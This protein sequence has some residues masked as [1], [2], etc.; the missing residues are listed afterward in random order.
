MADRPPPEVNST[1][2]KLKLVYARQ[3]NATPHWGTGDDKSAVSF[4][5][6]PENLDKALHDGWGQVLAPC[7]K[8]VEVKWPM[9][10]DAALRSSYPSMNGGAG[11]QLTLLE[12]IMDPVAQQ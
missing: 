10:M 2:L 4:S 12:H 11:E 8:T 6:M 9:T 3:I 7:M 1:F 5:D